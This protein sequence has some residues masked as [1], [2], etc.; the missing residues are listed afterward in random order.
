MF[1]TPLPI[2]FGVTLDVVH[3]ILTGLCHSHPTVMF[4]GL[5]GTEDEKELR[6]TTWRARTAAP[7]GPQVQN[8]CSEVGV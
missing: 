5:T 8:L 3:A 6:L 7:Q 1:K 4:T 2:L